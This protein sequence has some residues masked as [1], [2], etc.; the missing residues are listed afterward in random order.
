[1]KLGNGWRRKKQSRDI[2]RFSWSK[3]RNRFDHIVKKI[4]VKN[5]FQGRRHPCKK[6]KEKQ[7]DTGGANLLGHCFRPT[8]GRNKRGREGQNG[9]LAMVSSTK[10]LRIITDYR[11]VR[12]FWA[13]FSENQTHHVYGVGEC[14]C[15]RNC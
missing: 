11:D 3:K 5:F 7:C 13:R 10:K 4:S 9:V 2:R 8:E 12:A 1:V 15:E 6:G 14:N